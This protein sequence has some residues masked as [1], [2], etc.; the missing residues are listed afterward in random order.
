MLVLAVTVTFITRE[1]WVIIH[2]AGT[3]RLLSVHFLVTSP[4]SPHQI[5]PPDPPSVLRFQHKSI[6]PNQTEPSKF[7]I[8]NTAN[9]ANTALSHEDHTNTVSHLI[10]RLEVLSLLVSS[11]DPGERV[12]V[13][14]C[15]RE[16]ERETERSIEEGGKMSGT[17]TTPRVFIIRHGETEWSLDGRHT[18]TSDIPLTRNGEKRILATGRA[19]VGDDREHAFIF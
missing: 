14:V 2:R 1:G 7:L 4:S 19:L 8:P 5:D 16:R 13:C 9:T 3:R 6:K 15:V 12:S 17:H 11:L 18:G 10:T